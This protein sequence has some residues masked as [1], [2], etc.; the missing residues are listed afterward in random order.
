MWP[1]RSI[2][3]NPIFLNR[4]TLRQAVI[5]VRNIVNSAIWIVDHVILMK[6]AA[7]NGEMM[8]S[9]AKTTMQ[10]KI[11]NDTIKGLFLGIAIGVFFSFI[12][13]YLILE[14][15]NPD[16]EAEYLTIDVVKIYRYSD[17]SQSVLTANY[18]EFFGIRCSDNFTYSDPNHLIKNLGENRIKI[19]PSIPSTIK[20]VLSITGGEA[21]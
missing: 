21:I 1:E 7:L 14:C 17:G 13:C 12:A 18:H 8:T 19:I 3:A 16:Y 5:S 2:L 4:L 9:S 11:M 20:S 15:G 6:S 10:V